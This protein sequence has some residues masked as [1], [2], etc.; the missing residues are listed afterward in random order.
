[1]TGEVFKKPVPKEALDY[2]NSKDLKIGFDYRDVWRAEHAYS[3]TVA[4][5][6]TVDILEDIQGAVSKAI[7]EGKTFHQFQKELKPILQQKGWW[8]RKDMRD[9][10]TG[11][12]KD[13]QLGS[14]RRL[15]TIYRANMRTARGAGKWERIQRTKAALPYLLYQLGPSEHHRPEHVAWDGIMLPADDPFLAN[16]FHTQ[17]MGL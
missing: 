14:P 7:K 11:E 6:M 1:M 4:K 12:I 9:P 8:G 17:W 2:F 13:V 5:A 15:K 16:A 10:L 3:F